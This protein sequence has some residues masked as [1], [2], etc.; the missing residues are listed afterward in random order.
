MPVGAILEGIAGLGNLGMGVYNNYKTGKAKEQA[1]R[2]INRWQSRAEQ[3]L[4]DAN[5]N[6]VRMTDGNTLKTYQSLRDSYDPNK[7]VMDEEMLGKFDKSA[8]NVED[9][10]NGNRQAIL[11]D[12]ARTAQHTAAGSALG[13]SSGAL[14]AINRNLM[15]KDEQ[16]MRDARESMN[17]E[18]SF[19][20]GMYTD[21]INQQQQRLNA[22]QQGNIEQ[23]RMMQGDIQFD[24]QQRDAFTNNQIALGNAMAQ[25]RASLV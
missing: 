23:L 12:V 1:A 5:R 14:T 25:A 3:I 4:D 13:H 18:R 24:Q 21:F 19:D 10:L 8:Y 22:L 6:G 17:Q 2:E 16:L 11:D 20:Y 7:F 15:E 9:Y